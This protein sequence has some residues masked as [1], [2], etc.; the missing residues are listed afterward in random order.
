MFAVIENY[1]ESA[2]SDKSIFDIYIHIRN[3]I[4]GQ[5]QFSLHFSIGEALAG[6]FSLNT[7]W[8]LVSLRET[9]TRGNI[10]IDGL[11]QLFFRLRGIQGRELVINSKGGPSR[12]HEPEVS[13]Q[14]VCLDHL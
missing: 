8:A 6:L 13:V 9:S 10:R 2:F 12:L 4:H 1:E 11:E 14:E 7:V 3:L 5:C